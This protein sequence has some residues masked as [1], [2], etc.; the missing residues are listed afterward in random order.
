MVSVLLKIQIKGYFTMHR[1]SKGFQKNMSSDLSVPGI[2]GTEKTDVFAVISAFS[3]SHRC[4]L[5]KASNR[6]G[7][8][9][10]L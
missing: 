8:Q 7:E 2:P 9:G 10:M 4:S 1:I 5:K 6:S 3:W